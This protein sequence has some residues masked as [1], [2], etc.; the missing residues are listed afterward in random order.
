MGSTTTKFIPGGYYIKARCSADSAVAHAPPH[1][2]EI[3]DYLLSRALF[4]DGKWLKRGEVSTSYTEIRSALS[5]FV[6]WR[7]M[8]YSK[9]Q[10]ETAMKWLKA[11]S[12]ITTRRTTRG[13]IITICNYGKYQDPKNYE[14]HSEI[15]VNATG[16]PQ[17][18]D[19]TEKNDDKRDKD[20]TLSG[21]GGDP[22]YQILHVCA[23]LRA[24]TYDQYWNV[25]KG[26]SPPPTLDWLAL[27]QRTVAEAILMSDPI[28]N[29]ALFWRRQ[30]Q[31]ALGV[32]RSSQI[33]TSA[34]DHADGQASIRA[35]FKI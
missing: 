23:K 29:P 17:T 6:G 18:S 26:F 2:R 10:C 5:W 25:R 30:I 32:Q 15:T 3:W 31:K 28:R 1:V 35:A 7:K 21:D 27:S 4:K 9:S 16:T 34:L 8:Q 19:T 13:F 20:K 22:V 11:A 12:M 33:Q 14:S 24:M